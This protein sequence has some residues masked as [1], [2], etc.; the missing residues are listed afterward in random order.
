MVTTEFPGYDVYVGRGDLE[1]GNSHLGDRQNWNMVLT[2][3]GE[4]K[5]SINEQNF[6][7][8][9]QSMFLIAPG[10]PRRFTVP[11]YWKLY[12]LHFDMDAHISIPPELPEV[13]N[14]VYSVVLV[15]NDFE[16]I[17]RV[18]EEFLRVCCIKRHGWYLLA[19]NLIQELIL[20]GNMACQAA[21]GEH[22]ETTA[23][24]LGNLD[25]SRN[26]SDIA[27]KCG[28]SRSE[29]FDKFRST[30]GMTPAKYREQQMLTHTLS[31]LENSDMSIKEIAETLHF[32]QPSYLS[33][34][35][36]KAFG[37]SPLKYRRQHRNNGGSSALT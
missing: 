29:F 7:L 31:L 30:F 22:T 33:E 28:M 18:F 12:F 23:K 13:G 15:R 8:T 16:P 20:R 9:P 4:V 1:S 3:E 5:L 36:K 6:M 37:I 35:F 24:M 10:P 21:L 2:L 25:T 11:K 32:C 19:Y 26:I 14:G 34:R 17:L 27:V